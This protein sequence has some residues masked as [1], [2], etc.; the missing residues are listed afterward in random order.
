MNPRHDL[1]GAE[2]NA[3][4]SL[5]RGV[6][7]TAALINDFGVTTGAGA[8][9]CL[10]RLIRCGWVIAV[11]HPGHALPRLALTTKGRELAEALR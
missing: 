9:A 11:E 7:A 5:H 3:L 4:R 6:G 10:G 1:T 2:T 8:L